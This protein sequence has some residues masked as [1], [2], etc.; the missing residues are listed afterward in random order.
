V[1]RIEE[2]DGTGIRQVR[3][4]LQVSRKG[5]RGVLAREIEARV[6]GQGALLSA[7]LRA[8]GVASD[9][10]VEPGGVRFRAA[11][12]GHAVEARL[13]T[14]RPVHLEET[15]FRWLA[16]S[17]LA[18]GRVAPV[19]LLDLEHGRLR[20]VTLRVA[21]A[22]AWHGIEATR[23]V[24][25]EAPG[26]EWRVLLDGRGAVLESQGLVPGMETRRWRP[27]DEERP[28]HSIDLGSWGR[29]LTSGR[30]DDPARV[31]RLRLKLIGL[32]A[33]FALPAQV[34]IVAGAPFDA[35][36]SPAPFLRAT[37][38]LESDAPEIATLAREIVPAGAAP[39][40]AARLV[41]AWVGRQVRPGDAVGPPSGLATLRAR[42]GNCNEI[43][44]LAVALLRAAGVPARVA[45]GVAWLDGAF[46]YHA[47][48][49]VHEPR[50]WVAFD[51]TFGQ[52]PA[53][54]THLALSS[55]HLDAQ[56]R[57]LWAVGRLTVEV[58]QV[59]E[60]S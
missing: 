11:A 52:H 1:G 43:S 49:L 38:F 45:F 7:R 22:R 25:E 5:K 42:R 32:P 3:T 9:A 51:P 30:I 21:G 59:E 26:I 40:Q 58:V 12:N 18:T 57:I 8:G 2:L 34:E 15:A 48:A 55:G 17:G 56:A 31:R 36:T 19:A 47:W 14:R 13:A 53:D 54:A 44:A 60:A 46:R 23:V 35:A 20:R 41:S 33:A 29:V 10:T 24:V 39:A 50:G 16:A 37:P 4:R 27:G 28:V 6:D